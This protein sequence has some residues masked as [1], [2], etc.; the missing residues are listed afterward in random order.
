MSSRTASEKTIKRASAR[1]GGAAGAV[2]PDAVD[3]WHWLLSYKEV[4]G[5]LLNTL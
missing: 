5:G 1:I 2:G 4:S 3:L